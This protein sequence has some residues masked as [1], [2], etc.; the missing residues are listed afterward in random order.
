M[1]IVHN[2]YSYNFYFVHTTTV[3]ENLLDILKMDVIYPGKYVKKEQRQYYGSEPSE[4]VYANIYFEDINNIEYPRNYTLIL[5]PKIMDNNGFF[6][7]KGWQKYPY[8]G[9]DIEQIDSITGDKIKYPQTGIEIF[10]ND[11]DIE[12]KQKIKQI[13]DFIKN[14]S[15]PKIFIEGHGTIQHEILFDHPI[16]L[17][18]GNLLGIICDDDKNI[19]QIKNIVK[20]KPYSNIKIYTKIGSM[21]SLNELL[22]NN[23]YKYIKYKT[24][25]TKLKNMK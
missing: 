10:A 2:K 23:Y 4:Y 22:N 12:K 20:N 17:I 7:N 19:Q 15:L 24:K 16:E 9:P 1:T 3:F 18:N 14:P 13:H 6:F 25:Y 5:H 8:G 21:P 11:S